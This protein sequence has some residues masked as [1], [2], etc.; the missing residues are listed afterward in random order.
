VSGFKELFYAKRYIVMTTPFPNL[1]TH[2]KV[3]DTAAKTC[4]ICYKSSTSV[5][6]TPD[7]KVTSSGKRHDGT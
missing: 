4:D 5:L 6:I 3:A 1:Y 2:R 7:Q